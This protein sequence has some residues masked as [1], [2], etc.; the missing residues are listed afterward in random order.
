MSEQTPGPAPERIISSRMI[1]QGRILTLH[2]DEVA[3]PD[4]RLTTREIVEHPGA[5][6]IIAPDEQG[7]V[8]MVRQYRSAARRE[9]LELPAG[10]REPG[11]S[12]EACARRELAE[13]MGVTAATWRRVLGFY[14][15]PGFCTEYLT[16]F[17]A[18]GLSPVANVPEA[19]ETIRREWIDLALV[20]A[21]IARGD[22]RDAKSI[23]G[24]LWYL[25]GAEGSD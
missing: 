3:L 6:V 4:G 20:P 17:L 18:T 1:Y 5:V 8:A 21:M 19:D 16:V 13:E 7:R 11:E 23:A 10:T 22:I 9:L 14:S 15:A 24:L 25:H 2:V 12:D